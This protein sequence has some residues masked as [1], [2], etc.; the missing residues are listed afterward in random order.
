MKIFFIML[1]CCQIFKELKIWIS[2]HCSNIFLEKILHFKFIQWEYYFKS[3]NA[4]AYT[5]N[6]FKNVSRIFS[7]RCFSVYTGERTMYSLYISP[8]SMNKSY[9]AEQ[10]RLAA[11]KPQLSSCNCIGG[12]NSHVALHFCKVDKIL[13]SIQQSILYFWYKLYFTYIESGICHARVL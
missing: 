9:P 2:N 4:C 3:F 5:G 6:Y 7:W 10:L 12:Y 1:F 11:W 8:F 13:F